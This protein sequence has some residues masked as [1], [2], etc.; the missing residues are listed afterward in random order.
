MMIELEQVTKLYGSVIGVNDIN[1]ALKPGTYGLLGP[2]GSGKTTLI[3][4]ILGQLRPTLG[5]VRL[6]G[7]NPW[8]RDSLM[9]KIG[10][11]PATEVSYPRVTGYQWVKYLIRKQ[12]FSSRV[13]DQLAKKSLSQVRLEEAMHRPMQNYSLGMR[14]RAKLAQAI[15]HEPDLL[16]LDEPFNGLDPVGR[17]EMIQFLKDWAGQGR[18]LIL[19]SHILHEVEAVNPSFLLISG[20]RLLASGSPDQVRSILADT[21]NTIRLRTSNPRQLASQLVEHVAVDE[22]SIVAA[23]RGEVGEVLQ[24]ATRSAAQVYQALP[25][26]LANRDVQIYEMQSADESLGHLFSTLMKIHRGESQGGPLT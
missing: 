23:E 13:A 21:P 20:G 8:S 3:N 6:F 1:L 25:D 18:S 10:L 24:V 4:L 9:K 7:K 16:I 14:Q 5:A 12:G 2:N 11:C 19:A 22:I 26:L 17:M 15:A